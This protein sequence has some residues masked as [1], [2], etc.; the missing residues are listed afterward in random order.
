MIAAGRYTEVEN[1]ARALVAQQPDSG[2]S[3]KAL[4]VALRMQGKEALLALERAAQLLPDDPETHSNLGNALLDLGRLDDAAASYRRALL[5]KPDYAEAHNNL[6]AALRARGQ[7]EDALASFQRALALKPDAAEAHSN[8][9]ATLRALHRLEE[10]QASYRRALEFKSDSCAA[11][12]NLGNVLLEL[13]RPDEAVS[14]YR[15]ALVLNPQAAETHNNLGNALQM[16]GRLEDA[17]ASYRRA[18]ELKPDYAEAHS[19]L[20]NALRCF[21]QL[22]EAVAHYRRALELE[23]EFAE[24]CNNLGNALLDLGQLEEAVASYRRALELKPDYAETH[25]NLGMAL[26]LLGRTA[27]AEASCR[28]ACDS[29]PNL[30]ATIALRAELHAD[31]GRFAEAE[32]LFR[33][34][35]E[36]NPNSPEAW[37]AIPRVRRMMPADGPWLAEAQRML[38]QPQQP[39]QE[40]LLRYA[41]GKYFDDVGDFV[42]AFDS[43]RRAN[44][45]AKLYKVRYERELIAR[46]VEWLTQFYDREWL[47][48]ARAHANTS[49]RPVF[50]VGMPRSGTT[51]AEQILA[52]HPAVFGAGELSFWKSASAS[53]ESSVPE[54][55][56]SAALSGA[57]AK[58]YLRLLQRLSPD[59]LRV[60]DKMPAN[61]LH[62]GLIHGALPH[63]RIIHLRRNPVD[64]CLS[65][66]CQHF[67]AVHSYANDLE[68]LVHYYG[69]YRRLMQHWHAILPA[70]AILDV[71]Y[72]G[73]VEE[74]EAWSRRM[75]EFIDLPWD[76][77]CL[78]FH[79]TERVV[80]TASNWQVRQ[81]ISRSS[82][83]RWRNYE[84]FVGPL[85]RL[86]EPDPG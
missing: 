80:I 37:A 23:P 36:M 71:P 50:I 39:R 79:Q 38:A 53:Y 68:D 24:A 32:E 47:S 15:R 77:R 52:S 48:R 61:F 69:E 34:A 9:G 20:A 30:A 45:L 18:L 22:D 49:A 46:D 43:F 74:Q 31:Q 56:H 73:L 26:R 42:Q 13:G 25:S 6:G 4:G 67:R 41:V 51:L 76:A 44:E 81:R 40:L 65:I 66:Y 16:L 29:N 2:P 35:I 54:A 60:V 83:G 21:G 12:N 84:Q 19:N 62:L 70:D 33:R 8:L 10:A 28:R 85:L 17:V 11:H 63:A 86:L 72:E 3:W 75:L 27:E 58:D 57:L 7:L 78:D 64:T 82:V 14:S 55:Q 5:L 59:A 1:A